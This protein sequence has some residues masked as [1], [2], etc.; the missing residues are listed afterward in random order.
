MRPSYEFC[1]LTVFYPRCHSNSFERTRHGGIIGYNTNIIQIRMLRWDDF[2]Y[3]RKARAIECFRRSL[4]FE[5]LRIEFALRRILWKPMKLIVCHKFSWPWKT[6]YLLSRLGDA[7]VTVI[8]QL[9]V[10]NCAILD[11]T[12]RRSRRLVCTRQ[13]SRMLLR[14]K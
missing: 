2:R 11:Q 6:L 9:N 7:V 12:S 13:W 4:S 8:E 3:V 1:T 5:L 10:P 14:I